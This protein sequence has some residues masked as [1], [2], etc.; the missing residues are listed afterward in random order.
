MAVPKTVRQWLRL[1][2]EYE[3]KLK[4]DPNAMPRV[5]PIV[6]IGRKWWFAD[7]MLKEN[8]NVMDTSDIE[9]W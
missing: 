7:E 2:K 1:R 9:K 6:K 3:R 5:L 4:T 8:R